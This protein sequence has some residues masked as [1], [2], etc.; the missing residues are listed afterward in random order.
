MDFI[1]K[2][3]QALGLPADATEDALLTSVSAHA[4]AGT[5]LG[6]VAD[7]LGLAAG[8]KAEDIV[9]GAAAKAAD[10][11]KL[12]AIAAHCKAAG[13]ELEKLTRPSCRPS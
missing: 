3:R 12:L 13:L 7:A 9:A 4:L 6:K 5:T 10:A 8:A 2:L 11:G 1:A